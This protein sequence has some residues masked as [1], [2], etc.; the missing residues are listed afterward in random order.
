MLLIA[1]VIAIVGRHSEPPALE[2]AAAEAAVRASLHQRIPGGPAASD[3]PEHVR[4]LASGSDE[5]AANELFST[6]ADVSC[7][8]LGHGGQLMRYYKDNEGTEHGPFPES[9]MRVWWIHG[10][11]EPGPD[12]PVKLKTWKYFINLKKLYD[13]GVPPTW[14]ASTVLDELAARRAF[15]EM[16]PVAEPAARRSPLPQAA[17]DPKPEPDPRTVAPGTLPPEQRLGK[18][19]SRYMDGIDVHM[20][21]SG[22]VWVDTLAGNAVVTEAERVAAEQGSEDGEPIP[23]R[24]EKD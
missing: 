16:H 23:E 1:T 7:D 20:S 22:P 6:R 3:S 13:L 5:P 4:Y 19:R 10:M 8:D 2:L 18:D 11:F 15:H 9:R 14:Q 12:L 17:T 24:M 21:A